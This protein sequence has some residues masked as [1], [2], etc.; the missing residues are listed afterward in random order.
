[1]NQERREDSSRTEATAEFDTKSVVLFVGTY[2][3]GKSEVSVNFAIAQARRGMR[4]RL[5]DLDLVNPYFRSREAR[6]VLAEQGVGVILPP[7]ELLHADLPILS[8][9]VKG[10]V[11]R[12]DGLA[13]LDVGGD[14]VGATVLSSL[15]GSFPEDGYD[16][17]QVLN[18][19]RPFTDTVAGA[20]RIQGEIEAASRLRVTG[21]VSN[22]HLMEETDPDVVYAGYDLAKAVG[23]ERGLPVRFVTAPAA[24]VP[25]LDHERL[26]RTPLLAITRQLL[27]P[28]RSSAEHG[29][30]LFNLAGKV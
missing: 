28:W 4:V 3:S 10:M 24:V 16:L 30:A 27:P 12:P 23:A 26:D 29:S 19:L 8:P 22:S 18:H 20:L 17:L 13:V 7:P 14:N 11:M 21:L 15:A 9:A 25:A 2:G 6:D 5:A 1:V